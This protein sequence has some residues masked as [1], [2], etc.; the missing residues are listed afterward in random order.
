MSK[1]SQY[2]KIKQRKLYDNIYTIIKNIILQNEKEDCN[3]ESKVEVGV[4]K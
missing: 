2:Y 3:N 1:K 4:K